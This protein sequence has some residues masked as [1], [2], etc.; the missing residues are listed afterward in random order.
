MAEFSADGV[1]ELTA[2]MAEATV[3]DGDGV[4]QGKGQGTEPAANAD[5]ERVKMKQHYLERITRMGYRFPKATAKSGSERLCTELQIHQAIAN[6]MDPADFHLVA[7]LVSRAWRDHVRSRPRPVLLNLRLVVS[8]REKPPQLAPSQPGPVPV[9]LTRPVPTQNYN[10][11][12]E[13]Y[14]RVVGRRCGEYMTA[15]CDFEAFPGS[16]EGVKAFLLQVVAAVRGWLPG[17]TG[18]AGDGERKEIECAKNKVVVIPMEIQVSGAQLKTPVD[19]EK[20]SKILAILD[21]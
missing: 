9:R 13:R 1:A 7:P 20:F 17:K 4:P 18:G 10:D 21:P 12:P 16:V 14:A 11:L 19:L 5:P 3:S 8:G 2:K 6:N 15:T